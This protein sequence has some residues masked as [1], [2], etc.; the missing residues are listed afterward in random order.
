MR[1]TTIAFALLLTNCTAVGAGVGA[2][3]P[4]Y[5]NVSDL[6]PC[7]GKEAVLYDANDD[8]IAEGTLDGFK[9][10]ALALHGDKGPLT[11]R[12]ID[13]IDSRVTPP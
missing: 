12:L 6:Q 4:R 1:R 13:V 8:V 9:D 3:V 5:A 7:V 2:A 10:G 11:I